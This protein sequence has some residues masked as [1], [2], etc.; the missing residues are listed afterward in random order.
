MQVGF[1]FTV[2]TMKDLTEAIEEYGILP[3][4]A[5]SLP[6]FSIEEHAAPQVWFSDDAEGIWEW[7]GPVIQKTGCAYGK[8]FEKKAAFVSREW[9]LDLANCRRDGYDYEGFYNDGFSERRDK[10]LFDLVEAR[11]PLLSKELKALGGY[12]KGGRGGFDTCV[13]RLQAQCFVVISNFVYQTDKNGREYGWGIAEYATPE[14]FMGA[15]Y[16]SSMYSRDP[17]ESYERVLEHICGLLPGAK[18][19]DVRRFLR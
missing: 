2:S 13:N 5:N 19:D 12:G 4:F 8:F 16:I 1:D 17:E 9:F 11:G 3:Y 7:K 14:Q 6:G 10:Y 18:A 15:E